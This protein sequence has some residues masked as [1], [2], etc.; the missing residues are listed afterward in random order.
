M[1]KSIRII[2]LLFVAFIVGVVL[3]G[4]AQEPP[5]DTDD[6]D[7][8]SYKYYG[9]SDPEGDYIV[10]G[11]DKVNKKVTHKN[12]TTGDSH[13]PFAYVNE[14]TM[15]FGFSFLKHAELTAAELGEPNGGFVIFGEYPDAACIYQLFKYTDAGKTNS[16]TIGNP[17]YA[18]YRQATD[19]TEFYAKAYNWMKFFIDDNVT[20]SDMETGFAAFDGSAQYGKM[21]GA[22]YSHRANLNGY[23]YHGINNINSDGSTYVS[24]FTYYSAELANVMWTGT[25]GDFS[26]AISVVGTPSGTYVMDFGPNVGGGMGLVVPQS[27]ISLASVEG[28]YFV[29]V[30]EY[31]MTNGESG[32]NPMKMVIDGGKLSVYIYDEDTNSA[33]VWAEDL[34]A[35][36]AANSGPTDEPITNSFEIVASNNNAVSL[37][38][39]NAHECKGAFISFGTNASGDTNDVATMMFDPQGRF[40]GFTGFFKEVDGDVI[41]FGFGIKDANYSY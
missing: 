15:N 8:A 5:A 19:K 23:G 35:I 28:V 4:C 30:Y 25:V 27:D 14:T 13:G 2:G 26:D 33:A 10:V 12:L 7:T 6:G 11:I 21:Y 1:K 41:R 16:E 17:Q 18:V 22:G 29:M 24:N 39:Q 37:V 36:A 40:F 3:I 38:V 31:N 20:D 9:G 34:I 32:A